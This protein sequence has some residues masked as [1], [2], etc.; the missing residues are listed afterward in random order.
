MRNLYRIDIVD[1]EQFALQSAPC[2]MNKIVYLNQSAPKPKTIED[3]SNSLKEGKALLCSKWHVNKQ[4]YL[5]YSSFV[6]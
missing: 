2:G 5:V 4:D 1:A 6:K 3:L